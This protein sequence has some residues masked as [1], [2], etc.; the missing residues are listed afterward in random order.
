VLRGEIRQNPFYIPPEV[1][2][3][4]LLS[5]KRDDDSS[6]ATARSASASAG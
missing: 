2:L 5:G 1:Y 3:R 6:A 4:E